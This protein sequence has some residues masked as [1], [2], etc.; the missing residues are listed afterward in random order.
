MTPTP[1]QDISLWHVEFCPVLHP[2]FGLFLCNAV[3]ASLNL[4]SSGCPSQQQ[5][6]AT[7]CRA[8]VPRHSNTLHKHR[9]DSLRHPWPWKLASPVVLALSGKDEL[10]FWEETLVFSD[11]ACWRHH[12]SVRETLWCYSSTWSYASCFTLFKAER[13]FQTAWLQTASLFPFA[14]ELF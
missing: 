7:A 6:V 4:F 3:F 12:R 13:C 1:E 10:P 9:S 14:A 2:N 8:G 5:H 11:A